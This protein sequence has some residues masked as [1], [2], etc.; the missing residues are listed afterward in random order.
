MLKTASMK[1]HIIVIFCIF[2]IQNRTTI[3]GFIPLFR[4]LILYRVLGYLSIHSH[5]SDHRQKVKTYEHYLPQS[6]HWLD[7][8]DDLCM[9]LTAMRIL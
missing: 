1:L 5:Q 2:L 9:F 8:K 6:F 3:F 4:Q 7:E